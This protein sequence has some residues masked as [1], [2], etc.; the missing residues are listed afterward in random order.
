MFLALSKLGL[1]GFWISF[2]YICFGGLLQLLVAVKIAAVSASAVLATN[3]TSGEALA[4]K[5]Q[6]LTLGTRAF[7]DWLPIILSIL[8][9]NLF[10]YHFPFVLRLLKQQLFCFVRV[11]MLRSFHLLEQL[12]IHSEF[13]VLPAILA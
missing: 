13:F 9:L 12:V 1:E 5:L 3:N 4:V 8:K 2:K 11:A 7:H 10:L 6:T